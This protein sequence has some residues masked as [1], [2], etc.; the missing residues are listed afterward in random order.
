LSISVVFCIFLSIFSAYK[1]ADIRRL[2]AADIDPS[3]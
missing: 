2:F 1:K 3:I